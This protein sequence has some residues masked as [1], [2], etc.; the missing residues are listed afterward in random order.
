M[1]RTERLFLAGC[2]LALGLG[3]MF[4]QHSP[5]YLDADY[6]FAG[7]LRLAQGHG[8]SEIFP[9]NYLDDFASLPHPSHG[10]WMPLASL[11]AALPMA[12][13]GSLSFGVARLPFLLLA[14]C[15][16]PLTAS[17]AFR[18]SSRRELGLLAGILAAFPTFQAAFNLTTDN[19]VLY[20][21]L[22]GLFFLLLLSPNLFQSRWRSLTLGL[23]AAL[24]H[25][26]RAEGFLWLLL[27][28]FAAALTFPRS[29]RRL[30]MAFFWPLLGYLLLMA[31]WFWRNFQAFAAPL[32]PGGSR[33]LWLTSYGE[34]F[35]YPAS[36]LTPQRWLDSGWQAILQ[37]RLWAL[38]QNSGTALAAQ[39]GILLSPFILLG[40]W[41][42]RHVLAV[43]IGAAAWLLLYLL[44]SLVF[45]FAGARGSFFHAGAAILPL[46]WALAPL[47]LESA[48]TAARSRGWFDP[49][50]FRLFRLMLAAVNLALTLAL[51]QIRILNT[52]WDTSARLYARAEQALQRVSAPPQTPVMVANPPGLYLASGR[53]AIPLPEARPED[54]PGLFQRFQA[55]YL[56][57][58]ADSLTA[59][60][61]PLYAGADSR[62]FHL[63]H[64]EDDF[65]LYEFIP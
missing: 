21:L 5:G 53:P 56:L 23:L 6:Y 57:L 20:N 10:Y 12:L 58:E 25:L 42:L 59:W 64:A 41:R 46:A 18:L 26:A 11:L 39:A 40:A 32:A 55:G 8:F 45:P 47:G 51:L 13:T 63:L 44:M 65:H 61:K 60:S 54:I 16:P 14:A 33:A 24:M 17:L 29:P 48:V 36:T 62:H 22:G 43:K 4:L 1:T 2:A 3:L 28:W 52:P 49:R 38:A 31:P 9:W 7:A 15:V 35:L 50:A 30:M 37:V 34:T 19:F 27:A